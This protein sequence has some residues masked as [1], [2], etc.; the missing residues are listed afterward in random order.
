MVEPVWM[1][2]PPTFS[3]AISV[4]ICRPAKSTTVRVLQITFPA[5]G[6]PQLMFPAVAVVSNVIWPPTPRAQ[7][8]APGWSGA[9]LG[10][11]ATNAEDCDRKAVFAE[12][13]AAATVPT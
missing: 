10:G 7:M 4:P 2:Q 3:R 9:G 11:E 8:P 6:L 1:F 5:T 12:W 13:I